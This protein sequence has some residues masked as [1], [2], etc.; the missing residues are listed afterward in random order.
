[1]GFKTNRGGIQRCG[2]G[3]IT[4]SNTIW[5]SIRIG[6]KCDIVS[7][8]I[9]VGIRSDRNA[10]RPSGDRMIAYGNSIGGN[11]ISKVATCHTAII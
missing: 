7:V 3:R 11:G 6:P 9:G 2:F 4:Q 10:I 1:L 5:P 8:G